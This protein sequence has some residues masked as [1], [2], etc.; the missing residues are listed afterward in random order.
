MSTGL[1]SSLPFFVGSR[2][3]D[4]N[5]STGPRRGVGE[6]CR[7]HHEGPAGG[8]GGRL[9]PA[10][11]TQPRWP[12][13]GRT[14]ARP[15]VPVSSTVGTGNSLYQWPCQL[16]FSRLVA[17]GQA[18]T[19]PTQCSTTLPSASI[20]ATRHTPGLPA[21]VTTRAQLVYMATVEVVI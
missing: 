20:T 8:R 17:G 13:D 19:R 11:E 6:G 1:G 21:L 18:A 9:Q 14:P 5:R 3:E 16:A 4:Y 7:T 10:G 2:G 15:S 12:A